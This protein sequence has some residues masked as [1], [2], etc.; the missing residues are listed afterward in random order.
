MCRKCGT[1]HAA[2]VYTHPGSMYTSE[3]KSS[4]CGS[5]FLIFKSLTS[6]AM[7]RP[8]RAEGADVARNEEGEASLLGE[9]ISTR[10]KKKGDSYTVCRRKTS[11][12][13]TEERKHLHSG[14]KKGEHSYTE[15]VY[16]QHTW[17]ECIRMPRLGV[18]IHK[19][20]EYGA[21]NIL[22][23]VVYQK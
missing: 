20:A 18:Y 2:S 12:R 16:I 6:T 7:L 8:P 19:R 10:G 14:E 17:R 1:T 22:H 23:C 15:S 13:R 5:F 11:A 9:N 21:K 3:K 4:V